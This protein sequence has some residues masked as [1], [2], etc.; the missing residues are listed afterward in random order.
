MSGCT[1][2]RPSSRPGAPDAI[3][4]PG[5]TAIRPTEASKA[6]VC[7]VR[8]TSNSGPSRWETKCQ[9]LTASAYAAGALFDPTRPAGASTTPIGR[10]THAPALLRRRQRQRQR[11]RQIYRVFRRRSDGM[12]RV[13]PKGIPELFGGHSLGEFRKMTKKLPRRNASAPLSRFSA[14]LAAGG[15]L[16]QE[17]ATRFSVGLANPFKPRAAGRYRAGA[18]AGSASRLEFLLSPAVNSSGCATATY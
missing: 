7:Y 2:T 6:A 13:F 15:Q 14:G 10:G 1:R 8:N 4:L 3:C 9:V 11:Q 17:L 5:R 12:C 18:R 16:K